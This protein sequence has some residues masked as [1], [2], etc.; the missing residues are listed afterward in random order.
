MNKQ[1]GKVRVKF[2]LWPSIIISI[3]GS[4]LLTI[5]LNILL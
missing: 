4:I 3:V 1:S 5:I 2:F